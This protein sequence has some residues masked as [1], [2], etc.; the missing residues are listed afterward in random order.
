MYTKFEFEIFTRDF[1][2]NKTSHQVGTRIILSNNGYDITNAVYLYSLDFL[3]NNPIIEQS[4]R[5]KF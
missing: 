4:N 1:Y 2:K 5:T 3:F